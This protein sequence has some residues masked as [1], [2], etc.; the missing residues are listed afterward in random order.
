VSQSE[1]EPTGTP[2]QNPGTGSQFLSPRIVDT[3]R[4]TGGDYGYPTPFQHYPRGPGSFKMNLIFDALVE[5]SDKG[6]IPWLAE[7]WDISADGKEYTFYLRK[8]VKWSDGVNFTAN[9]VKFSIDYVKKYPPVSG[10]DLSSIKSVVVVDNYTIK[11][12]ISQPIAPFV[13]Q[14][15][16]FKIIPEHIWKSVTD[17]N[18]YSAPEAVIGTGPYKLA[19]YSKEHGTYKFVANENFWGPTV[20]V[21]TLEFVPVSDEIAAFQ[22]NVVDFTGV[23]VDVLDTLKSDPKVTVFQQPAVWGYELSFNM[24]KS[25]LLKEVAVR[26]A[27]AYAIDRE[28]LLEKVGRGAGKPGSPGI[29]PQDHIWYNP[30]I[31]QYK[32]DAAKAK[33]VLAAAGWTDS[34]GDGIMDKNGKK[35]S[36]TMTIS[37]DIA[38]IG[39][40]VKERLKE[41]GIEVNIQSLESKARDTKL[42]QGDFEVAI[43]GYGGWGGDADYL[44]TKFCG[45]KY[46]IQGASHNRP[47]IGYQ[48]DTVDKL[49]LEQFKETNSEKRKQIIFELQEVLAQ[50]VPSI[51]LYNTASYEAY[52]PTTYDGWMNMFDHHEVTHSKLSY[53]DRTEIK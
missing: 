22:Q 24:N 31:Q 28:E 32:H 33:Q 5:K 35:L 12:G 49:A 51:P 36:F 26:Q 11:I 9:D 15:Y 7:K 4:L 25:A 40:L 46:G 18:K 43:N 16:S 27:F 41:A 52:R 30:D 17:P 23:S 10:A 48:N 50:E 37:S 47:L 3:I 29:L 13:Y 53:L 34:D 6:I 8:G 39:E 1:S 44:R 38:R 2:T 20:R 21:K 19:E 14:L 42:T 45:S